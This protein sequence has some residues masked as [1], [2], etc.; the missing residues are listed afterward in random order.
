MASLPN[1]TNIGLSW[2]LEARV[3]W[4][5]AADERHPLELVPAIVEALSFA[6]AD[7]AAV[8]VGHIF[9]ALSIIRV[10][11][12]RTA[13]RKQSVSTSTARSSRVSVQPN[14]WSVWRASRRFP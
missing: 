2:R 9:R 1:P 10:T 5:E 8:A 7:V 4:M 14:S 11:K 13:L 3:D 6:L 12:V